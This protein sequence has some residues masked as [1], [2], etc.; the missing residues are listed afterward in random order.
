MSARI[1]VLVV[2]DTALYR[3][4]LSEAV[5]QVPDAELVGAA[6]S[7]AL[8]LK[9]LG[10][11]DVDLVLLD[12]VMPDMDGVQTLAQIRRDWPHVSVALVSGVTGRD[13]DVTLAALS[14][15]ALD[16]IPKPQAASFAE[17]MQRII[18]DLRRVLQVIIIR[19]LAAAGPAAVPAGATS[20]AGGPATVAPSPHRLGRSM[21]P[22]PIGLILIGVST[23]GP[24]ALHEVI[25]QLPPH[26]SVPVLI[27]Q[28]MPAMFTRSLAE[29]IARVSKV[30]VREAA[31]GERLPPGHVLIAPGGRH[32]TVR[33]SDDGRSLCAAIT[34]SA[35]VHSCRPSV[36][37]MFDSVVQS[38][39][40]GGVAVV[41]LTGM[42]EDGALGTAAL[43]A[44]GRTWCIA[45]DQ[46]SCVVYGMPE[47]IARRH[48]ADEVLPLAA[49]GPRLASLPFAR[50]P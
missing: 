36:D 34:D 2:D 50:T 35:P 27:V 11:G 38:G 18:V 45:Q 28:H 39:Y 46:A 48:L 10:Q 13:A 24:K 42:G 17:G 12:V 25:P 33:R 7:G 44:R 23:G 47:A 40:T 30:P 5:A 3:K 29:Q 16:F 8:A 41:I 1:R 37:V 20:S 15:G 31:D 32:L 26:L 9:R 21:L 19:R 14:N 49:I 6:A 4:I 43:K 22:P